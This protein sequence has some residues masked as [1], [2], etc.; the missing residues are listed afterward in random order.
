MSRLPSRRPGPAGTA[1]RGEAAAAAP[2]HRQLA[3]LPAEG[4]LVLST[5]RLEVW[6][7]C[8]RRYLFQYVQ[9]LPARTTEPLWIGRL[10]HRV[11]ERLA[12]L[13]PG[14]RTAGTA[15]ELLDRLWPEEPEREGVFADPN[16]EEAARRRARSMLAGWAAR[17][18]ERLRPDSRLFGLELPLSL[19]LG[20]GLAF[21]GR[22]DRLEWRDG[23]LEL[24]DYKTGRAS[25]PAV[26]RRSLQAVGYAWLVEQ[27]LGRRVERVTFWFLA[28][29]RLVSLPVDREACAALPGELRADGRAILSE[30]VYPA[31]PGPACR[32]CDYLALCPEGQE[33]VR[34]Y[35]S[36]GGR[37]AAGGR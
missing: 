20:D 35:A 7:T 8:R 28:S 10:V 14:E 9:R 27:V 23:G 16:R 34:R 32:W 33:S 19:P 21:T 17:E 37:E 15:F 4:R 24:V 11:L 3:L 25:G 12:T 6:R 18:R 30:E 1:A 2:R 29:D 5:T 31:R 26:L 22:V 13:P 36:R